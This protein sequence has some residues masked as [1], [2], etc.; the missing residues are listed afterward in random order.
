MRSNQF[1]GP[2]SA[3]NTFL[4]CCV[5]CFRSPPLNRL[6][7][8]ERAFLLAGFLWLHFSVSYLRRAAAG[9]GCLFCLVF[10]PHT[11]PFV[12][13]CQRELLLFMH[14][15]GCCHALLFRSGVAVM[16]GLRHPATPHAAMC[17]STTCT[18]NLLPSSLACLLPNKVKPLPALLFDEPGTDTLT[19]LVV[20]H[21]FL[22]I[23]GG[24]DYLATLLHTLP[25]LL[26]LLLLLLPPHLSISFRPVPL[27]KPSSLRRRP[28]RCS[29]R[30]Q[31]PPPPTPPPTPPPPPPTGGG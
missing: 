8:R 4:L 31:P 6:K 22:K 18:A 10:P 26:L 11:C 12:C 25:Q 30:R 17:A 1:G 9:G 28:L 14:T 16:P 20:R 19:A 5:V 3:L 21:I 7:G 2:G 27:I 24:L 15:C 29:P 23:S 13:L